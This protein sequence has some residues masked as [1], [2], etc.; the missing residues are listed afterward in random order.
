MTRRELNTIWRQP[1]RKSPCAG[2]TGAASLVVRPDQR[3]VRPLTIRPAKPTG[4]HFAD[5]ALAGRP[6]N[7]SAANVAVDDLAE[8]VPLLALEFHQLKLGDRGEVG[9]T[10]GDLDAR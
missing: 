4:T 10:G 3:V 5:R 9:S 8:Q 6:G 7:L 2:G 1:S